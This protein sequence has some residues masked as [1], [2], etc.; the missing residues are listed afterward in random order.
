[1]AITGSTLGTSN[2]VQV[3]YAIA[4]I[5]SGV[6]P[7]GTAVFA[8]TQNNTIVSEAGVPASPPTNHARIF[9]D[10]GTG[11][12]AAP[13]EGP[14]NIDT[15]LA[16]A[17]TTAAAANITFTLR[18]LSGQTV[19]SGNGSLPAGYHRARYIDQLDQLAPNFNLPA[20]FSTTTRFGTLD[21]A[22]SQP[23]SIVALRL[24]QNQRGETLLTTTPVADLNSPAVTTPLYFPQVVD[25]GGYN[26]AII[27][28]NTTGS[29][30]TG[31][32]RMF[33]DDGSALVVR[34]IN[35]TAGASFPY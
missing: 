17:N 35:G 14:V 24:T 12:I 6:A 18:D 19:A 20:N 32:V 4:N 9:I 28:V 31:T 5:S 26:T 27:L 30:E 33:A 13:G 34:P 11:V 23:L 16:V 21:I 3:G 29:T 22:S 10:F 8:V 15:G 25:G 1:G 2:V 7:Y